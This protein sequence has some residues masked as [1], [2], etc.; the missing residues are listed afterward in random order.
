[1]NLTAELLVAAAT[2]V[3]ALFGGLALVLRTIAEDS[4]ID[5]VRTLP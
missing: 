3:T 4:Q 2:L 5:R 1:V